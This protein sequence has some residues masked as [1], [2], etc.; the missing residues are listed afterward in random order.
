MP[1]AQ[2]FLRDIDSPWKKPL[3]YVWGHSHELITEED[4][5]NTEKL[6]Q[7]LCNNDKIWYATN[8]EIF[9]Y[10]S[11]QKMLK[12]SADERMFYNPAATD[13]WVEKDKTRIIKIPAGTTIL[14]DE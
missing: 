11:A 9:D 10:I 1:L 12:I 7:I 14:T 4:W 3:F 6:L 8:G 13:V 2:R 5:K